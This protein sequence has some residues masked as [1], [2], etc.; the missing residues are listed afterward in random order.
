MP[1]YDFAWQ[2]TYT[3]KDPKFVPA[4]S[5]LEVSMWFDNSEGNEWVN[6]PERPVSWGGMTVKTK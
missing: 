5:R 1:N 2:Q 3:F 6:D 4:G